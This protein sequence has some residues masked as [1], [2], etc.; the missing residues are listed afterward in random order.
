MRQT[1]NAVI[2]FAMLALIGITFTG[3]Q[4]HAGSF[5]YT[6][7]SSPSQILFQGDTATFQNRLR[8]TPAERGKDSGAWF[9]IKQNIQDGFETTFQFQ[10]TDKGGFGADGLAFVI[11]NHE[12]PQISGGGSAI[13]FAGMDNTVAVKFDPYHFKADQKG[14]YQPYDE[15]AV[16]AGHS[17]SDQ[18]SAFDSIASAR[19]EV[20]FVDQKIHTAKIVYVPG[21]IQVFVDDFE[22]PL[23]TASID[24]A[25]V[26]NLDQGRAWVG[27]TAATGTDY[28]N[29][30]VL[31]WS[32]ADAAASLQSKIS[33]PP[34]VAL[35]LSNNIY[36]TQ[37][38]TQPTV[39]LPTDSNFGYVLPN[40]VGITHQ[41][42]ASTDLV[43]WTSLTN[44]VFYFRD[45]GSTNYSKRF[46][47]FRK[48]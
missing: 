30:D 13:G 20:I 29:Q 45:Q 7:F 37:I 41:I 4:S 5:T 40:D 11:Q 39:P 46:Y 26:M 16:V 42:E 43:H 17:P 14:P 33:V 1:K 25:S 9:E 34:V 44:T 32:F 24:L 19:K 8:L 36:E 2:G 35:E 23:I 27:F 6:D 12:T 15:V 3:E 28:Y 18:L 38:S 48:N 22:N 21:K 10:F 31:S 47:R